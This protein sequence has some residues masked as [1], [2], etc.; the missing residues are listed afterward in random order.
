MQ[1]IPTLSH[2][3]AFFNVGVVFSK[4]LSEVQTQNERL[5]MR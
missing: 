2:T 1:F 5:N 4:D 3:K